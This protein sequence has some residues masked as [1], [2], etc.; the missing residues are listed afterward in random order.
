MEIADAAMAVL[1]ADPD[2]SIIIVYLTSMPFFER[3]TQLLAR[4]GMASGKPI[5][6]VVLPGAA[7]NGP[8][9]ALRAL[10]CPQFDSAG[11]LLAAMRGLVDYQAATK[12]PLSPPRRPTTVPEALPQD[13]NSLAEFVARYGVPVPTERLCRTADLAREAARRIGFPVALKGIVSGVTH[14]SDLGL[15]KT[16]LHSDIALDEAWA[17]IENAAKSHALSDKFS[18]CLVQEQVAPG[19]ELILSIRR[20]PQFGPLLLVGAGGVMV[21]LARDTISAPAPVSPARAEQLLRSLRLAPLFDGYR[22]GDRL[23]V[24]A[25]AEVIAGLSWLAVDLGERL[26]VVE[27][28]PLIIGP[29]GKGVRAVDLRGELHHAEGRSA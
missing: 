9:A 19:L 29:V 6:V 2:V 12:T 18:G 26:V 13:V 22:G 17:A 14:K 23:D 28:N 20:D 7:A 1:A 8:R 25:A 10:G 15:V 24:A 16:N 4:A 5:A 27:I 3:R 11:D 21:E